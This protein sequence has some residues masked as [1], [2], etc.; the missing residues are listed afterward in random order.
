MVRPMLKYSKLGDIFWVEEVHTTIH[1]LN[2]GML[3]NNSEIEKENCFLGNENESWIRHRRMDHMNFDNFVK[4]N[5]KE[6]VIEIPE[7]SKLEN[8]LCNHF[9]KGKKTRTKFK[10]KD[11]SMTKPLDIVHTNLCG[12]IR[13]KGLN[14]EQYFMQLVDDYTRMIGVCFLKKKLEE[15]KHFKIQK[16]M[17]E[18][19]IDLKINFLRSNN[20]GEFTSK[21]FM[22]FFGEHGIKN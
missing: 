5:I 3:R 9:L 2:R 16:K 11:Y 20:G 10:S 13:K 22:D 19:E 17:V 8:T 6:A 21:E 15:F 12:P 14:G 18:T 4:I 7:I 1:I